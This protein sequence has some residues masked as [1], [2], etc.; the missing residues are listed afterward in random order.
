MKKVYVKNIWDMMKH[1]RHH[2]HRLYILGMETKG[3]KGLKQIVFGLHDI[4]K[5]LFLPWLWKYYGPKGNKKKAKAVY[6]RMNQF[7]DFIIN[8]VLLFTSYTAEQIKEVKR[9]EKIV[10]VVDRHC[11]PVA[12]EEFNLE[13]QRPLTNFIKVNDLPRAVAFKKKW[14]DRFSE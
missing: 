4:E 3:P 1:V 9:Y 5:F 2:R 6:T 11:D 8:T 14:M 7:G 12:L 10:D 13:K